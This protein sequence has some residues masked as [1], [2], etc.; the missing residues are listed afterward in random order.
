MLSFWGCKPTPASNDNVKIE[1]KL[2]KNI[3][4]I[5]GYNYPDLTLNFTSTKFLLANTNRFE[6]SP[7]Q[8]KDIDTLGLCQKNAWDKNIKKSMLMV[9]IF[10]S[11]KLASVNKPEDALIERYYY[12]Y[13]Q[14]Q[15]INGVIVVE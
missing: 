3:V 11:G 6:I 8:T 15:K 7:G 4:C 9:F 5:L 10:D 13:V 14:L 12:T 2:S 1:N